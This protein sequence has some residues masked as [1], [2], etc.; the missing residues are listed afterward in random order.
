MESKKNN[1]KKALSFETLKKIIKEELF[2]REFFCK[3]NN[4]KTDYS[5]PN[6]EKD[7]SNDES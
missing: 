4:K 5:I 2:Y 1:E 6:G 7:K 3:L